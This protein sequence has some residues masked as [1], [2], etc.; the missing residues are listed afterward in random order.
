[1]SETVV[2]HACGITEKAAFFGAME[3]CLAIHWQLY[4]FEASAV[5]EGRAQNQGGGM[6]FDLGINALMDA[7]AEGVSF[8]QSGI[9]AAVCRPDRHALQTDKG[10]LK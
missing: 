6:G 3:H 4:G 7:D 8:F 2:S 1:M 5:T 9:D 10:D